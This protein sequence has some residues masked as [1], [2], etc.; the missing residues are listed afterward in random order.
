MLRV[1]KIVFVLVAL[2]LGIAIAL[3]NDKLTTVNY[4]FGEAQLSLVVVMLGS[5]LLGFFLALLLCTSRI[6]MLRAKTRRLRR[7][8]RDAEAELK[9]LR[10]LPLQDV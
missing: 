2:C 10:N 5:L 1:V 8:L 4:L 9:N 7:Q 6:L 3:S